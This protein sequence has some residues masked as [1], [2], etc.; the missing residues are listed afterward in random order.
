MPSEFASVRSLGS[1]LPMA[2]APVLIRSPSWS[3]SCRVIDSTLFLLIR[4]LRATRLSS[5]FLGGAYSSESLIACQTIENLIH[6][7][8]E[9]GDHP[10]LTTDRA[11]ST[12]LL[13]Q[14]VETLCTGSL[15]LSDTSLTRGVK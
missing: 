4:I 13:N 1:K 7:S 14:T 10:S 12:A 5:V 2:S 15:F 3:V 11:V 8:F 6:T 9:R